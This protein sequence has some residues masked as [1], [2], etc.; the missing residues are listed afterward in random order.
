MHHLLKITSSHGLFSLFSIWSTRIF[1]GLFLSACSFD[2]SNIKN[3]TEVRKELDQSETLREKD[4][5]DVLSTRVMSPGTRLPQPIYKGWARFTN[6]TVASGV[7]VV[8]TDPF[9]SYAV[10]R[11]GRT[12]RGTLSIYSDWVY[13][14]GSFESLAIGPFAGSKN[15]RSEK[16][17]FVGLEKKGLLGGKDQWE[18]RAVSH[19]FSTS[20]NPQ[21]VIEEIRVFRETNTNR[22][23]LAVNAGNISSLVDLENMP[24]LS[25]N[26]SYRMEVKVSRKSAQVKPLVYTHHAVER[27]PFFD[28]GIGGDRVSNDLI[29][30]G[31]FVSKAEVFKQVHVEVLD[32]DT[33]D[34]YASTNYY[35]SVV[36]TLLFRGP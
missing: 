9:S 13:T 17:C 6:E 14:S 2:P 7:E 22:A 3:D 27:I 1:V 10:V 30:S 20:E 24:V 12:I 34:Q 16:T 29:Y 25:N 15:F 21:V 33:I 28:D 26:C 23:F 4:F 35:Q 5:K 8:E 19:A 31:D 18:I 36:W 32:V 11:Y